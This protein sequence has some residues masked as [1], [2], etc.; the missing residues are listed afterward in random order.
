MAIDIT[1]AGIKRTWVRVNRV[2][3]LLPR[4]IVG[5]PTEAHA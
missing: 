1:T 2:T 4:D 5:V 3:A